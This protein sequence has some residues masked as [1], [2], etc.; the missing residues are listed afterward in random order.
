LSS[1]EEFIVWS[2]GSAVPAFYTLV[3]LADALLG[4]ICG[5]GNADATVRSKQEA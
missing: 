1:P 4:Q 2:A 3:L 5:G